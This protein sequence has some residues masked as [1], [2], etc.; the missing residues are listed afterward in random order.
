MDE[1]IIVPPLRGRIIGEG[2]SNNWYRGCQ[3]LIYARSHT[4]KYLGINTMVQ[5]CGIEPKLLRM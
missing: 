5:P 4:V 3:R 1:K 2:S